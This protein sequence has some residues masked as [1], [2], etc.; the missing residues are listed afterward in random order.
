LQ[1]DLIQLKDKF[2]YKLNK[3]RINPFRAGLFVK[4][5]YPL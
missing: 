4:T 3:K 1:Y 2:I 5:N